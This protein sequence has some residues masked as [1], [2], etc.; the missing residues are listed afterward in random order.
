[1]FG[2]NQ[3]DSSHINNRTTDTR[4]SQHTIHMLGVTVLLSQLPLLLHLPGWLTLPGIALTIAKLRTTAVSK[5]LLQPAVTVILVLL[6]V[7]A[8]FANY[9]YLFGRDPCVAFLFLLLSFKYGETKRNYDASLLVILCA[10]LLI[11]QF[12]FRQSLVSAVISI[13]SMYFI[14]LSLFVVQR[15]NAETNTR[16]MV[17][18]TAKLFLQAMPI[19][20]ILFVAVPRISQTP[21][22]NGGSGHATTGLSSTMSPGSFASLSKSNEVAFRVEFDGSP[23]APQ[24]R[25]W[26]GPVLTGFDGYDWFV[27]PQPTRIDSPT[28]PVRDETSSNSRVI[29]YTVTMVANHQ[30]WLLALDTPIG[31]PVPGNNKKLKVSMNDELQIDTSMPIDQPLRYRASSTLTDKFTAVVTP[32]GAT[33]ITTSSNP[34]ARAFAMQLRSQYADDASFVQAVLQWFN[35]EPFHYTLN[36]PKLGR[37]AIDDFIFESRRGFCEHYAGSFVFLLRA[38]GIPARVV[39]GYQGGEMSDDYM[40]VR[41]SDAHAWTEAFIDSQWQRFDPTASVAPERVEQ[42][43]TEALRGDTSQSLLSKIELPFFNNVVLK[44][45]AINFAWQRMVIGFDSEKQSAMWRKLGIEKP[46][47][48]MIV[49]AFIIA[50]CLWALFILKPVGDLL[51]GYGRERLKPCEKHWQKL[52]TKLHRNGLTRLPGETVT[53]YIERAC[54]KWPHYRNQLQLIKQSYYDGMYSAVGADPAH[55]HKYALTIKRELAQINQL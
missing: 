53:A 10:F 5:P 19:A 37:N 33:L 20:L 24:E 8:V 51:G 34:E 38:A 35:K 18:T 3:T 44:W 14:G 31:I 47:A 16:T 28:G 4:L 55:H 36:P 27:M 39:T 7:I 46:S 26:R 45:D 52:A 2:R 13:P 21:W 43:A 17:H 32:D 9:G 30:P 12:F 22:N 50:A 11:T 23:P 41:Q 42:G 6:A 29:N 49:I 1:M 48:W 54:E 40:I 15:G 25:Y